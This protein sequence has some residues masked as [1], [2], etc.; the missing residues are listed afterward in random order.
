VNFS[1]SVH[2]QVSFIYP[3]REIY[4]ATVI[5]K[6]RQ[7][8]LMWPWPCVQGS[9]AIDPRRGEAE[10][11]KANQRLA[12]ISNHGDSRLAGGH[13]RDRL[14]PSIPTRRNNAAQANQIMRKRTRH[15]YD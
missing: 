1:T 4:L 7:K 10:V 5:R 9:K 15:S 14:P 8:G 13:P 11:N 3:N 6:Q 12:L 2:S